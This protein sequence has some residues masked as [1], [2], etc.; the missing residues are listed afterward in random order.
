MLMQSHMIDGI[1]L[2]NNQEDADTASAI[3]TAINKVL[4]LIHQ[5][6]GLSTPLDCRIYV[7]TS[8]WSFTFQSAPWLWKLL[9]AINFPF[10][11]WRARKV[12]PYAGGLTQRYG[13]TAAIGIKPP[14][15]LETS[16]RSFG[17]QMYVPEPD[18]MLRI[19]HFTCHELTHAC[20]AHLRLPAWLNEGLAMF[21]VDCF[22][23][24]PTIRDDTLQALSKPAPQNNPPGYARLSRMQPEVVIYYTLLGY[25]LVRYLEE[26]HPGF[27]KRVLSENLAPKAYVREIA[28]CL[29][30]EM[31]EFWSAIPGL[32]LSHF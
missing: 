21:T 2:A 9:L 3:E 23:G 16:D 22:M 12:W 30:V 1:Y 18:P 24:R 14:R 31:A 25:W 17:L 15:L 11:A 5:T 20:T 29:D 4:R 8:W 13:R 19:Q 28:N 7:M 26:L 32:L 10:W 27:L 6:W